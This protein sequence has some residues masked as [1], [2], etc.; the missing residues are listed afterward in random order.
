MIK[1]QIILKYIL[2]SFL[3]SVRVFATECKV[4]STNSLNFGNYDPYSLNALNQTYA[5]ININ[6]YGNKD[7]HKKNQSIRTHV[8]KVYLG[9]GNSGSYRRREMSDG[10]HILYYNLFKHDSCDYILG[11]GSH[12]T[13][14][15]TKQV[16][17]NKR[18]YITIWGCIYPGQRHVYAGHYSDMIPIEIAF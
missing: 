2:I 12:A 3:F 17:D 18:D 11:D 14:T 15:I 4:E 8:I 7:I 10:R 16:L 5:Q 6:C 1:K 13:Q 9:T